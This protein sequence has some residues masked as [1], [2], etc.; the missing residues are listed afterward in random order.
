MAAGSH[1][2]ALTTVTNSAGCAWLTVVSR[3]PVGSAVV[4]L[5]GLVQVTCVRNDWQTSR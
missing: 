1:S 3:S 5:P 2:A 4:S